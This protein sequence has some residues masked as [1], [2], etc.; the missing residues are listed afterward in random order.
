[1]CF[2]MNPQ[3]LVNR[4]SISDHYKPPDPSR[5][6]VHGPAH[7]ERPC[8]ASEALFCST[9]NQVSIHVAYNGWDGCILYFAPM[10]VAYFKILP[11]AKI[12]PWGMINV[13]VEQAGNSPWN[14]YWVR[15][16]VDLRF[17]LINVHK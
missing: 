1:M 14:D 6:S 12:S 10:K 13:F 3:K 4:D 7:F 9:P 16:V 5:P 15:S 17:V 11:L 2:W 8:S